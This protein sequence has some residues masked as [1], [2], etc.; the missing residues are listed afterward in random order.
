[1]RGIVNIFLILIYYLTESIAINIISRSQW[2]AREPNEI[3]NN[4]K[5]PAPFVVIHHSV[6]PK[7]ENTKKCKSRIKSIQDYHIDHNHWEDIGYNFLI[8]GDGQ[9]YEGRGWRKAGA[10][11]P[12]YNSKS[13]GICLIGNFDVEPVPAIQTDALKELLEFALSSGEVKSDYSLIGHKQTKRTACPGVYL[14][15]AIKTYDHFNSNITP[16]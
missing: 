11:A 15:N 16:N 1:M 9:I 6:T 2:G 7:C 4:Y 14:M 12:G 8:G 10:H 13:I 5:Y 3:I